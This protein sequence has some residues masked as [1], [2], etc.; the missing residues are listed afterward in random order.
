MGLIFDG[1]TKII[2]LTPGTTSLSVRDL[3]SR[4]VDWFVTSDNSKYAIAMSNVGGDE[5]DPSEGIFVPIYVFLKNGWKIKPQE[6]NHTLRIF[7]GIL[8]VQGGGDPFLNTSG[9]FVVRISYSQPVQAISFSSGG[10]SGG[11][12]PTQI[13]EAV[14]QELQAELSRIDIAISDIPSISITSENTPGTMGKTMKDILLNSKM[15][16]Y[17]SV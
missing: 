7:D 11:A 15:A 5:I 14:R 12:T 3:W 2:S 8:L 10:S 16:F 13:A 6:A 1:P 9:N 4:W 17:S